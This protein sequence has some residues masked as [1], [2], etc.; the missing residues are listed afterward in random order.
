MAD[1][2]GPDNVF[3]LFSATLK[4]LGPFEPNPHIAVGLSGGSD[5]MALLLLALR[6][7]DKFGG[8]V[9]ALI[10]DHGLRADSRLEA[11]TVA[12]QANR[13]GAQA[14]VLVWQAPKQ[15]AGIQDAARSAR[16]QLMETWCRNN[17]V[18]HLLVGHTR[19]D[20][21]ET[22]LMRK[23]HASGAR[24]LAGMSLRY[25]LASA[26]VLRPL[27][28]QDRQPLRD[29]LRTQ[30]LSWVDDPSNE[31]MRFERVRWRKRI[32]ENQVDH[33][34]LS[35]DMVSL[36]IKRQEETR[37]L[38]SDAARCISLFP[39][40]HAL[41]SGKD[42]KRVPRER[43][44]HVLARVLMVI[45]GRVHAPGTAQVHRLLENLSHGSDSSESLGGCRLIETGSG[46]L[47][48]R[49][50]RNLPAPQKVEPG[51]QLKWDN[52]FDLRF[53][54]A[55]ECGN[56]E[57]ILRPFEPS[58][59]PLLKAHCEGLSLGPRPFEICKGLPVLSDQDG[60]LGVPH[61]NY[62]W[63]RMGENKKSAGRIVSFLA[64]SPLNSLS[65]GG[66]SVA[67]SV[68]PTIS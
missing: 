67:K 47:V 59:W 36:G 39:T 34:H 14:H 44:A 64:F 24:G 58:D 65:G 57:I 66:F 15:G 18:L 31:D 19:N 30:N 11:K 2:T 51:Q 3:A 56:R 60:L 5:S 62:E 32:A 35:G 23:A 37:Q 1:L 52:R 40:G 54:T 26:Q 41:L 27:L 28:T 7:V 9:S 68:K 20:Q 16:Y 29:Y 38:A 49:E 12:S 48:C 53:G 8:Q 10:V 46:F 25:C 17:H 22:H 42:L 43:G 21:I 63:K 33:D 55:A 50:F 45:G 6:W 13:L 4:K 61:L